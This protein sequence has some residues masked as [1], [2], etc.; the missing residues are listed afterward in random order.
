MDPCDIDA[1]PSVKNAL[2]ATRGQICAFASRALDTPTQRVVGSASPV[3][4][5]WPGRST[6]T[7][8]EEFVLPRTASGP[9]TP[10]C[11]TAG[12]QGFGPCPGAIVSGRVP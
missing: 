1:P 10:S 5:F 6:F 9:W 11:G 7:G 3:R 2:S 8:G 12:P 4:G